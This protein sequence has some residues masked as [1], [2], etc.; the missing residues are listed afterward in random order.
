MNHAALFTRI[1][2]F[3]ALLL[4]MVVDI[5]P[6]PILGLICLYILLFRPRWFKNGIDEIYDIK[7][8]INTKPGN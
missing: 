4:L 3:I 6:I 5:L 7:P 2:W 8:D 1:K